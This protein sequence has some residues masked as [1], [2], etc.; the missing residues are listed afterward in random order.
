ML[1]SESSKTSG[2]KESDLQRDETVQEK[3][4]MR[5]WPDDKKQVVEDQERFDSHG[6]L[7][8][9]ESWGMFDDA[10]CDYDVT[11]SKPSVFE[12]ANEYGRVDVRNFC[13][14]QIPLSASATKSM[15]G[16]L[17]IYQVYYNRM[18]PFLSQGAVPLARAVHRYFAPDPITAVTVVDNGR[19][20]IYSFFFFR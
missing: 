12:P 18:L 16:C 3:K 5:V 11:F 19:F 8:E 4:R 13:P 15:H 2:N 9:D 14:P 7:E 20:D 6:M 17:Y 10:C 1:E